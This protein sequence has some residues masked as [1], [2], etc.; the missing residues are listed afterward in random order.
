MKQSQA[1]R[2]K[3]LW[4]LPLSWPNKKWENDEILYFNVTLLST[5]CVCVQSTQPLYTVVVRY[6][7]HSVLAECFD[8]NSY[9][10]AMINYLQAMIHS[11]YLKGYN[12][13]WSIC[14][15]TYEDM[16]LKLLWWNC[17]VGCY[18]IKIIRH[19]TSLHFITEF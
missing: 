13:Y 12:W 5:D 7:Q 1:L 4:K 6:I 9:L 3:S 14:V 17:N 11:F 15:L 19:G 16:K 10:Q 2:K 18:A 8:H